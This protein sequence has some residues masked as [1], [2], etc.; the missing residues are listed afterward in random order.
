MGFSRWCCLYLWNSF[1]W[2]FRVHKSCSEW[3]TVQNF[4][5]QNSER[6]RR[7]SY[8]RSNGSSSEEVCGGRVQVL[9]SLLYW[10]CSRIFVG[11]G[12]LFCLFFV[13]AVLLLIIFYL[14]LWFLLNFG[15][16]HLFCFSLYNIIRLWISW[17]LLCF[18]NCLH[19]TNVCNF[20]TNLLDGVICQPHTMK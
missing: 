4:S 5:P 18:L 7:W 20:R 8:R 9:Y 10:V 19:L 11:L 17:L 3:K 1:D 13:S 14:C 16:L 2:L 15:I 12:I 6:C